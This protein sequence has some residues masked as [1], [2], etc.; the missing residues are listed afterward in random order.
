MD[1]KISNKHMQ[2]PKCVEI[3]A[4]AFW[5]ILNLQEN[6]KSIRNFAHLGP[7]RI[8]LVQCPKTASSTTVICSPTIYPQHY[9]EFGI[10]CKFHDPKR[11]NTS[12]SRQIG[13]LICFV[14]TRCES[15][16]WTRFSVSSSIDFVFRLPRR[17]ALW[18]WKA[19]I[20]NA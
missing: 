9:E 19:S 17:Y 10:L 7:A 1:F 2:I 8:G 18:C 11:L 12:I 3:E 4:I 5:T 15:H 6:A 14:T 16:A 13:I 20:A